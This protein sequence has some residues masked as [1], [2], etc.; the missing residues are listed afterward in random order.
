MRAGR[1]IRPVPNVYAIAELLIGWRARRKRFGR[2]ECP[3]RPARQVIGTASS[4]SWSSLASLAPWRDHSYSSLRLCGW[5]T[6]L[7]LSTPGS[8]WLHQVEITTAA[9]SAIT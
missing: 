1:G 3:V 2:G 5:W 6:A 9:R 8:Q 4:T 7:R